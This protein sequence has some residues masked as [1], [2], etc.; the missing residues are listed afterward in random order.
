VRNIGSK[1]KM[2]IISSKAQQVLLVF[3]GYGLTQG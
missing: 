2:N 3:E 1:H